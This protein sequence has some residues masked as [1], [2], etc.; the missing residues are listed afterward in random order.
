M[1]L[2]ALA[3]RSI[4]LMQQAALAA[5]IIFKHLD[6]TEQ[7]FAWIPTRSHAVRSIANASRGSMVHSYFYEKIVEHL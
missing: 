1:Q 2:A 7:H 3:A 4:G 5:C 6:V